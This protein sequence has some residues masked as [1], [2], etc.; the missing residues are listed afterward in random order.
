MAI[1]V[2][3][4]PLTFIHIP[5]TGGS[6][7]Q[8][9]LIDNCNGTQPK[10]TLHC[11]VNTAQKYFPNLGLTFCVVRNPWDWC[12]S[13]YEY[14]KQRAKN[15]IEFLENNPNKISKHKKKNC[16]ETQSSILEYLNKGFEYWLKN[17]RLKP[18]YYKSKDVDLI[19]KFENLE[20]E[21]Y[22]IQQ[23]LGVYNRLPHLNRSK[24]KK[25]YKLYYT[26]HLTKI[27]DKKFDVDIY[28]FS[29]TF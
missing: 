23:Y 27:V 3:D 12:V 6:S 16:L 22:Q 18:Q 19:L 4:P 8:K 21:F 9:W 25:D 15:R 2:F 28:N 10:K 13:W 1:H 17:T 26:E 11:N 20:Q 5:K 24:R 14:K 29:Y 7:I